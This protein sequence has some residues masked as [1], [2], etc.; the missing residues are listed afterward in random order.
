M[1]LVKG[2][3]DDA[4]NIPGRIIDSAAK[5]V[6]ASQTIRK[7]IT[8]TPTG[9]LTL[10]K[11]DKAELTRNLNHLFGNPR[12]VF[13]NIIDDPRNTDNAW[14]EATVI[15]YHDETGSDT[16]PY[17]V[18]LADCFVD[19]VWADVAWIDITPS[20]VLN[21]DQEEVL[22]GVREDMIIQQL[23]LKG[24][25]KVRY[26]KKWHKMRRDAQEDKA[27]SDTARNFPDNIAARHMHEKKEWYKALPEE[28]QRQLMLCFQVCRC[29]GCVWKVLATVAS[30]RP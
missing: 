5:N 27:I 6:V 21:P 10:N 30:E 23:N 28:H 8:L 25:K 16:Q 17:D 18:N 15:H 24:K 3:N 4:W 29:V 12:E 20:T 26:F 11:T 1:L 22:V 19:K 9:Q 13:S 2:E 7:F 14:V